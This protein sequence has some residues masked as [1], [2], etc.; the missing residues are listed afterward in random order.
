MPHENRVVTMTRHPKTFRTLNGYDLPMPA[1]WALLLPGDAALTR[2]VKQG[3]TSWKIEE[4][5]G[6]RTM[7]RGILADANRIARIKVELETERATPAYQKKLAA[8]RARRVK[9]QVAYV[10]DFGAAVRSYLAFAPAHSAFETQLAA[11]VTAH[12]TPVGSGTVART[13]R[14]PIEQRAESAVIA[15]LRHQTTAYDHMHIARI[16]GKRR[17]VRRKLAQESKR[18]LERYRKG[19]AVGEGCPLKKALG[20]V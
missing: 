13:Q 11:A 15:W 8:G 5:K 4:K 16:K 19:D 20:R 1:G 6:R 18:L 7:S 2:R 9:Q 10:E 17:E 12:A 3:G 14:I